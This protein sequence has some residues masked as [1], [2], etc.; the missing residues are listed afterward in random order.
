MCYT[1][2]FY[3]H[4]YGSRAEQN[5]KLSKL[6]WNHLTTIISFIIKLQNISIEHKVLTQY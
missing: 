1:H 5:Y 2:H 6:S 3:H 4:E